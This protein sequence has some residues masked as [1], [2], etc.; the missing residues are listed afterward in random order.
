MWACH[1]TLPLKLNS[2]F[3]SIRFNRFSVQDPPTSLPPDTLSST[4]SVGLSAPKALVRSLAIVALVPLDLLSPLYW[5][6][7]W[8]P[9]CSLD[10][11][12]IH[13][14]GITSLYGIGCLRFVF[15]Q[16]LDHTWPRPGIGLVRWGRFVE[17]IQNYENECVD[18]LFL[19]DVCMPLM[20]QQYVVW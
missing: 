12:I 20:L 14:I 10:L 3:L 4:R 5:R 6:L 7:L 9:F 13:L 19:F 16:A 17:E 8:L 11:H 2:R 1:S 18:F 15:F